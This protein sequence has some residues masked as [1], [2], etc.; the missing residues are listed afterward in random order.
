MQEISPRAWKIALDS[1]FEK[2]MFRTESSKIA[3]PKSEEYVILNC[4]YLSTFTAMDQLSI[5]RFDVEHIAPKD[6]MKKLIAK[7]NGSGLPISS[8]ANLCYLPEYVNRSKRD[9]NFY[10]DTN[11]LQQIDLD[12]V[13]QKY[14]FT[15]REDLEWMDIPYE[16]AEDF[17][18]LK[19]FFTEFCAARFETLKKLFCQSMG[20]D[21]D[22]MQAPLEETIPTAIATNSGATVATTASTKNYVV[23]CVN[24]AEKH[25]GVKLQRRNKT[26][27]CSADDRVGIAIFTSKA[28]KQGQREK[29]WFAYRNNPLSQIAHCQQQY[30]VYGCKNANEVLMIPVSQTEALKEKLNFSVDD[31]GVIS[32]WHIFLF[33]D[34]YGHMTH[35]ISKPDVS[36]IDVDSYKI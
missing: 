32:H 35:M 5:D 36:E 16:T 29:Y 15:T 33:R 4:I 14:S 13:E 28:Y 30:V 9:R 20:I 10:Q 6:Q 24:R 26:V 22:A 23:E 2:S 1:Y 27:Y 3:G 34:I 25:I 21:Y 31:N 8:I 7:C 12:V 17:D 18:V 11:Y 19:Q